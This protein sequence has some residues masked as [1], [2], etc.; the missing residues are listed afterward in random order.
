MKP[1]SI[2]TPA[3]ASRWQALTSGLSLDLCG[4]RSANDNWLYDK[5]ARDLGGGWGEVK[6]YRRCA[7]RGVKSPKQRR[8]DDAIV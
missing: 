7:G 3:G 5:S 8:F 4:A 1:Q 2:D 6:D